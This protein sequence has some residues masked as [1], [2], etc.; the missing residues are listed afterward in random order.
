MHFLAKIF[1]KISN[2]A[3]L[4]C[5]ARTRT[6]IELEETL[7][8]SAN[9]FIEVLFSPFMSLTR[10]GIIVLLKL[11]GFLVNTIICEMHVSVGQ[12]LHWSGISMKSSISFDKNVT[13]RAKMIHTKYNVNESKSMIFYKSVYQK[14]DFS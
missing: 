8:D 7:T 4:S 2:A 11:A 6:M 14:T 10:T 9:W 12:V 3:F 1:Y 13:I 5:Y